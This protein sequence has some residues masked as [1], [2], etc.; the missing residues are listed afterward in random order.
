VDRV[1]VSV[2]G[3]A[4]WNV[5]TGTNDWSYKWTPMT[6]G[7]ATIKSRAI[8][9]SKNVQDPPTQVSVTVQDG[10]PPTSTITFPTAGA[11]V[12]TGHLVNITGTASDTG[13]GS[14]DRVEVSV[15]GGAT[16]NVATGTNDWSYNWTPTTLGSAT[17][18]SRAVDTNKNVQDPPAQVIV[19]VQDGTPPTVTTFSPAAG[20]TDV[21]VNTDVTVTFS[22]AMDA[23]T[24]NDLTIDLRDPANA[25]VT[26]TVSYDA[27]T[28]TATLHPAS[29]LAAGVTYRARVKGGTTDPR[30]KDVA[31]N[32]LASN[33]EAT[34]TTKPPAPPQV[35]STTPANGATDVPVGIA[36]RAVFS[37][38]IDP[39]SLTDSTVVL[40]DSTPASIPITIK[41]DPNF[42]AVALVPQAP[43]NPTETYTVILRGGDNAPHIT[44]TTNIPLPVDKTWTFTTA[45]A[46]RQITPVSIFAP[47]VTPAN[48][49]RDDSTSLELGL[50]FRSNVDGLVAGVW[51]YKGGLDNGDTHIGHLW[52]ISGTMLGEVTFTNETPTGWQRAL[53]QT[54][55]P[56]TAN[57]TYVVSYLDPQGHYAADNDFFTTSGIDNGPLHALSNSETSGESPGNGVY[58]ETTTGGFPT[59]T[60]NSTNYYVDVVFVDTSGPPQ[61]ISTTP[62]PGS[63]VDAA[64]VTLTATFSEPIAPATVNTSTVLLTDTA[65]LTVPAD[66][67]ISADNFTVTITPQH[68]LNPGQAYTVTLKGSITDATGTPLGA[69]YLLSFATAQPPP[70]LIGLRNKSTDSYLAI[71]RQVAGAVLTRYDVGILGGMGK[72][73]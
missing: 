64:S 13:G 55:I 14:V 65:G 3:G 28:V 17:I 51:F 18:K 34:F 71:L 63:T 43:L 67:S 42:F 61:V 53:F 7:S 11:T 32:A 20:A 9:T 25:L 69:D 6:L 39:T 59:S 4:T 48:P 23:T 68:A 47:T 10:T 40:Q 29:P 41:Y 38:P 72:Y 19:T 21:P 58:L 44:D 66:I 33:A 45:V 24:V 56:I 46:Q 35:V 60:F 57:T 31:G 2:D 1:E 26:A 16:W 36:P 15:D 12:L 70:S 54:P 62:L 5:A 8:D 50:K 73:L 52:S 37:K 30:V 22:E 49:I 27:A